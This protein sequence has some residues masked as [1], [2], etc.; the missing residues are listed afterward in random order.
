MRQNPVKT[1]LRA[2]Q[3]TFGTWLTLGDLYATRVLA[4][5]SWDWLTLDIEHSAIDWAQ[6]TMIFGAVADAGCVPL[7]RI[8]DG[9]HTT[10]KRTLDAGAW[11]V[12]V[13]MVD[14]VEQARAAIAAAKYPP[15]G[16]RS[17]GGGMH[18]MNFGATAGDYYQQ[19][20]NE[21]L[22]VLQTESPTGVANAEEIYAL[23]GC[24]AIFVGPN[25]LRAQMRSADGTD[26]TPEEHEAMIQRVIAAGQKVNCPTGMHTMEPE[27]ALQRAEE[28]MQFL[29]VG[30]DLRMMTVYA[31]QSLKKLRPDGDQRD[32]ARY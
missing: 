14:T 9:D 16:N 31:Q 28:G 23:P 1:K 20:N 12:I 19:A 11:G 3:P 29:A 18:A 17:V 25:D 26:P 21:I 8:P 30:S 32:L 2:G 22:V 15:L 27:E 13:P 10:I 5:M 7:A 24:D 6:A 4:R